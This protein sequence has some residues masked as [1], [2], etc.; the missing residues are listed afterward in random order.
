MGKA[1]NDV[2]I[3]LAGNDEIIGE[4]GKNIQIGGTGV[5]RF[6]YQRRNQRAAFRQSTFVA[7]DRITFALSNPLYKIGDRTM[8]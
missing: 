2:L 5:D 1:G 4:A 6:I 3:G 8:P 7:S